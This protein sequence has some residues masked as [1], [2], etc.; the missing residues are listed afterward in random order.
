MSHRF[1]SAPPLRVEAPQGPS[2]IRQIYLPLL[3]F[4]FSLL[5][6]LMIIEPRQKPSSLF[7]SIL[8]RRSLKMPSSTRWP[9]LDSEWITRAFW[10]STTSGLIMSRSWTSLTL[11]RP[12]ICRQRLISGNKRQRRQRRQ[13]II[14]CRRGRG[15][16]RNGGVLT[17]LGHRLQW[18]HHPLVARR[19]GRSVR[20]AQNEVSSPIFF[21]LSQ[22]LTLP[23]ASLQ[24]ARRWEFLLCLLWPKTA[25]TWK[26]P[27]VLWS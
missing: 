25:M 18:R 24:Q 19:G 4:V 20:I 21:F 15:A 26:L 9:L 22:G 2:D 17:P 23:R 8:R 16:L 1:D 7:L 11:V 3:F 27:A 12:P 6:C 14:K 5:P 10:C 13:R